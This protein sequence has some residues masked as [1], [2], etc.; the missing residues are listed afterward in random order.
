N[1][2]FTFVAVLTLALGIG[3]NTAIFSLV[4]AT[5]LPRLPVAKPEELVYAFSGAPNFP[6]NVF[7]YPDY[8]ELRDQSQVFDGLIAWGGISASLNGNE[9]EGGADLVTGAIV[10]GNYF[11]V[12]GV[13]AAQGRVITR[14]DDQT[15]GAHPV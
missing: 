1:P 9:Q 12:L 15:P 4:N 2:S 3:A 8:A 10:T 13:R 14:E 11:E 7:S 5:L 6:Y